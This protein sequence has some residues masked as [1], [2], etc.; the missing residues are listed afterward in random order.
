MSPVC[1]RRTKNACRV[2]GPLRRAAN[3]GGQPCPSSSTDR[4]D[5]VACGL[6]GPGERAV[7]GVPG[8]D[9]AVIHV[10]RPVAGHRGSTG[11]LLAS[12]RALEGRTRIALGGPQP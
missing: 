6:P 9:V 4:G 1:D 7:G 10:R 11:T 8:S 5:A 2:A 12:W 3:I